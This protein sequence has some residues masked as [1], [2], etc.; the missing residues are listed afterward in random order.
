MK[1]HTKT[2]PLNNT[3]LWLMLN[4]C[5]LESIKTDRFIRGYD[6]TIIIFLI[7]WDILMFY[8]IFLSPQRN[9]ALLLVTNIV[10]TICLVSYG[11]T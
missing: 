4:L 3:K 9:E 5:V 6:G 7:F 1:N 8:K 2:F 10:H 11:T